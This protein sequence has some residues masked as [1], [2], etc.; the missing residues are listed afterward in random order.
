MKKNQKQKSSIVE[1]TLDWR[2]NVRVKDTVAWRMRPL[3]SETVGGA[4]IDGKR[5]YSDTILNYSGKNGTSLNVPVFTTNIPELLVPEG[6]I[7]YKSNNSQLKI[8]AMSKK[9][10]SIKISSFRLPVTSPRAKRPKNES[11]VNLSTKASNGLFQI[12]KTS[13]EFS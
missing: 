9:E 13:A 10:D 2:A 4:T 7:H 5:V 11:K 3:N 8:E 12:S 6:A 1:P